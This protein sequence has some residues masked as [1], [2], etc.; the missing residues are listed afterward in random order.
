MCPLIFSQAIELG[1]E[2]IPGC[3]LQVFVYL[4]NPKEAGMGALVSIAIST[5]TTGFASATI[6]FDMD[7]D[8]KKRE[9]E[10]LFYGF[11]PDDHGLRG[12]CFILMLLMSALHNLSR[13]LGCAL[14]ASTSG[15]LML[16]YF[17]GGEILIFL[18]Y[19]ICR[20]DYLYWV[21]VDGAGAVVGSF[22][23]RVIAKT[24]VDFSGCLQLRHPNELGGIAFSLSMVYAQILPFVALQ[25]YTEN[26]DHFGEVHIHRFLFCS[27]GAWLLT[28]FAFFCTI[29]LTFLNTFVGAKTASEYTCDRFLTSKTDSSK[30]EAVM[31]NRISFIKPIHDEVRT[32]VAENIEL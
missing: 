16:L 12:R 31:W 11:I 19:K 8:M 15:I 25:L 28:S 20:R 4:N 21:R 24:V 32:W 30:F 2:S 10:A 26:N 1:T 22:I 18:A 5:L 29:D 14:L 13:S 7:V 23:A 3:V 6:T 27:L 17:V 9:N